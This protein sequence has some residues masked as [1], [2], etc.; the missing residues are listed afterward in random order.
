MSVNVS[1]G[2]PKLRLG[3][4][5]LRSESG[6]E[7][8]LRRSSS[9]REDTL[10]YE[11]APSPSIVTTLSQ[12]QPVAHTTSTD[13]ARHFGLNLNENGSDEPDTSPSTPVSARSGTKYGS[14]RELPKN[15]SDDESADATEPE[16]VKSGDE[17]TPVITG[18][19]HSKSHSNTMESTN[20]SRRSSVQE[21][22]PLSVPS[23]SS[24]S[25]RKRSSAN[26]RVSPRHEKKPSSAY[27]TLVS[28]EKLDHASR[29][30]LAWAQ[31]AL[32]TYKISL[33]SW[34][35]FKDG[36]AL[37]HLIH[38]C[39]P[40]SI[41]LE[42]FDTSDALRTL[43]A[44]FDLAHVKLGIPNVFDAKSLLDSR[45]NNHGPDLRT[46]VLYL[47]HFKT[48]YEERHANRDAPLE[49]ARSVLAD[50]KSLVSKK[51]QQVESLG[52][53]FQTQCDKLNALSTR[54][55]WHAEKTYLH[56]RSVTMDKMVEMS[57]QLT[58]ELEAQ[59]LAL[60]EQ[61]RLL[62]D[63]I[64]HLNRALDQAKGEKDAAL[65]QL[66]MAER[67][68]AM[69][70]LLEEPDLDKYIES[71][72]EEI[73]RLTVQLTEAQHNAPPTSHHQKQ[74]SKTDPTLH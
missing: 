6:S 23:P 64:S 61:N 20:S 13:S 65:A 38:Y 10:D 30:L 3:R 47:A 32:S 71:H 22:T 37:V 59:N 17:L 2:K 74:S 55:E 33:D 66:D 4:K 73:E 45:L 44:A 11:V 5:S 8:A 28:R 36:V 69:A 14:T 70:E 41:D 12:S 48:V 53:A 46:F 60:R 31:N 16:S 25:D 67:M 7:N 19:Y 39:D 34:E 21:S 27:T 54:D 56:Q 62:T 58:S 9:N 29:E 1:S 15:W 43:E 51:V 68:K 72:K 50:L 40:S 49:T 26:A 35:Q 57:R 52:E 18:R 24:K 63:K 42:I